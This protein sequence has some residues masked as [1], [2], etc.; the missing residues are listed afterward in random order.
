MHKK[1]IYRLGGDFKIGDNMF[2]LK[3]IDQDVEGELE[4][5]LADGWYETPNDATSKLGIG[6]ELSTLL[7][8]ETQAYAEREE[9]VD[10]SS[11]AS[12][13]VMSEKE[14]DDFRE[15]LEERARELGIG[16]N[17]RTTNETLSE[18]IATALEA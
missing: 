4:K 15:G 8:E 2:E 6:E 7:A 11:T 17:V 10:L 16:F 9:P 5:H 1:M 18:R 3:T 13:H 12:V 14:K